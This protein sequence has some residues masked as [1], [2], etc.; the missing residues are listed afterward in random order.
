M[1]IKIDKGSVLVHRVF[2]VGGEIALGRAETLLS[3][4]SR[5]FRLKLETDT[6]KAIIIKDAPLK[7][8]LGE[9]R[10]SLNGTE[11]TVGLFARLWDYGVI[12][13]TLEF[14]IP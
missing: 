4:L 3:E 12:S 13:V 9:K 2:D 6:R 14:Q 7:V 10:L 5:S 11:F 8:E 1:S